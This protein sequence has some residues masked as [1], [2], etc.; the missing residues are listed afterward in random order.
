MGEPR[1]LIRLSSSCNR[2]VD[3]LRAVLSDALADTRSAGPGAEPGRTGEPAVVVETSGSS[4][5]P[6]AVVLSISA[7]RASAEATADRIGTGSWVLALEP[8]YVAGLQVLVRS[9]LAGTRPVVIPASFAPADFVAAATA[10]DAPRYTSLVPAQLTRLMDAAGE[11][12][13]A[14]ALRSFAA[15]LVG[16]QALPPAEADRAAALGIRLVRTYGSSETSG[17]C[18]YDGVPLAGVAIRI[19]DGEVQVSGPML[20]A[21]YLGDPALTAQSFVTDEAGKR[22][23]RT[24]D[25]GA[26]DGVLRV[27]GRRDNVIVSGGVNVSLDRVEQSVR[28]VPGLASAVVVPAPDDRWGQASVIVVTDAVLDAHPGDRGDRGDRPSGR[29]VLD[30]AR[31][32]VEDT[33]GKAARPRGLVALAELPTLASGKPDRPAL[34]RLVAA[35]EV[36]EVRTL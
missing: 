35:A 10:V 25:T 17:G 34:A 12:T 28:A 13:V 24:G 6:K 26:F 5:Y 15:I 29:A 9:I 23:Y 11:E 7:L 33:I 14:A 21:E 2:D 20:A 18:V 3:E 4:G 19:E 32:A 30:A 1:Q 36:I 27:T 31:H 16:G 22:W 8:A